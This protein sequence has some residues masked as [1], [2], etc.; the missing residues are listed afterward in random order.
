MP[1]ECSTPT[2]QIHPP[3]SPPLTTT[4]LRALTSVPQYTFYDGVKDSAIP[5][6]PGGGL[7][8]RILNSLPPQWP[9]PTASLLQFVLEGDNRRDAALFAAVAAKVVGLPLEHWTQPNS[10]KQG[11]FGAPYDRTLYG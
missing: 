11:L 3:N 2:Y 6:I 9:V 1:P 7:T 5:F 10:W 4:A 8:R